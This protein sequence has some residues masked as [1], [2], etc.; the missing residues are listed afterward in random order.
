MGRN[1]KCI[2]PDQLVEEAERLMR[3]YKVDQIAV[4]DEARRPVGLL[5]VQDL[6]GTRG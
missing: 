2:L 5:D 4:I 6:L 1:P 3:E